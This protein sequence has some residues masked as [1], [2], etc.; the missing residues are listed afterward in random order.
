MKT[1]I[2]LALLFCLN[3]YADT[4]PVL[5]Q[6][7]KGATDGTLIGNTADSLRVVVT[8]PGGG[9]TTVNQG[10]QGLIGSPWFAQI[11]NFP[12]SQA[13]TGPLTDAQLRASSVPVSGTFFQATQPISAASL[14]LPSG[15]ATSA[16]QTTANSSLSSI[17]TKTP[18]L[19][20]ALSAASVPVVLPAAQITTLTP[21][22]TVT[23]TQGTGTNLH[24]VVDSGTIALGAGSAIVGSVKLT[25][26]TNTA[27]VNSN[28]SVTVAGVSAVGS[29]PVNPPIAVSG[30]DGGG[31]K[32]H[33]LTDTSGRLEIDTAQ[34]LPLPALAATSTKQSDGSQKSQRVDGS[35]NVSP[36]GDVAARKI[37]V[38][39]TDGTNSQGY[40]SLSEAKAAISANGSSANVFPFGS[41]QAT[42]DPTEVF[43]DSIDGAVLDTTDN[44]VTPVVAGTGTVTQAA[45]RITFAVGTGANN[46]AQLN[47][48]TS[49]QTGGASIKAIGFGLTLE[50]TTIATGNDRFVG[51][52]NQGTSYSTSN[53]IKD[54]TGFEITPSG[55]LQAVIYASDVLVFSQTLTPVIDG[56]QHIYVVFTRGNFIL[57]Y[58]DSL[59]VPVAVA[60]LIAPNVNSLPIRAHSINGGSTTVGTPTMALGLIAVGDFGRNAAAIADGAHPWRKA[61]VSAAG[62]LSTS[63]STK[64]GS[65][66]LIGS[67]SLNSSRYLNASIVGDDPATVV[68]AGSALN[69]DIFA[70]Q[71]I[72][73]YAG[74]SV[75]IT[76]AFTA[77]VSFQGSNDNFTTTS[78]MNCWST[79]TANAAP[80]TTTAAAGTFWCPRVYKYIRVRMTAYTS[81]TATATTQLMATA[82]EGPFA[83]EAI[84]VSGT[85]TTVSTVTSLTTL[86]NGQTAHSAASTGSPVRVGGRAITTLDTTLV[87]GDATDLAVTSGQQLVTKEFASSENDWNATSGTTPLAT[88]TSTQL[89][90]AGAASIRNFV[91]SCQFYN[92]SAVVA[93]D[94]EILDGAAVIWTGW[95]PATTAALPVV[96]IDANFHTPLRGTAA[97]AMNVKL[98]TT[99]A[100][101]YYNCQ[102]YQSF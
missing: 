45:G 46:A 55:V 97:T 14:P 25:D 40:T 86:A 9:T 95:L 29:A 70:S 49:I 90:A 6:K 79:I 71:D 69:A 33:L 72:T 59:S 34:S 27:V 61:T 1:L 54:G 53:P 80:V 87:Q 93:T 68:T 13:V 24:T 73:P 19:G 76:G 84:V 74:A 8:N 78:A 16:N 92:N 37:F 2:S 58:I 77:T 60:G 38:Q 91:T 18:S 89:K 31:L 41:L 44:W 26:G 10:S 11:T 23:V 7:I 4:P 102:G 5:N 75:Q 67:Q 99:G 82:P 98:G 52:G 62:A 100:S 65:G 28:G 17:D 21:P 36:A 42:V 50:P 66:N 85:V 64:D 94:V 56:A 101:V 20:Q 35:G 32:R 51:F 83:K 81:G 47:S 48:Q 96:P 63:S 43:V 57:W 22:T 88:T 15:A 12:G 39:P 3:A 30:V